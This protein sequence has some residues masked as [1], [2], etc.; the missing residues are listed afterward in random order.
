MA[1]AVDKAYLEIREG[2][3]GGR[4]A[5]GAHLTAQG[6][7]TATGLSRTP[8][9]EAMRRLHAEG[10]IKIIPHRGAFVR[11]LDQQEISK[12]YD[13]AIIL[14]TYAAEAAARNA[15]PAQ[16][17][18][19]EG[20]CNSMEEQLAILS[21]KRPTP[22]AIMKIAE[23][24]NRFHRLIVTAANNS[25]LQS[26]FSV[27]MEVPQIITTF[28]GYRVDEMKR[29]QTQHAELILAFR[30]RDADWARSTMRSHVLAARHILLRNEAAAKAEQRDAAGHIAI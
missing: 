11:H 2:I 26:A 8:V 9:R 23:D 17:S 6:L 7:A 12:I 10:L 13:L 27:I 20:L 22:Q 24:N 3:V 19:L 21:K 1:A 25:W 14:E 29:S 16:L 15:T 28:Q 5:P 18:E 30:E 4:Y